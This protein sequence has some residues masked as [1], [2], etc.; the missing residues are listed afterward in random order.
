MSMGVD[1][2]GATVDSIMM[3]VEENQADQ[4]MQGVSP[5]AVENHF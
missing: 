3:A 1:I 2:P 4:I 5:K